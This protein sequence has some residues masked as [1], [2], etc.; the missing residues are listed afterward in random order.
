MGFLQMGLGSL[1]SQLGAFLGG[2]FASTLPL[3][4]AVLVLSAACAST[5]IFVVPRRKSGVM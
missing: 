4:A 5:M 3:T 1:V 2:H